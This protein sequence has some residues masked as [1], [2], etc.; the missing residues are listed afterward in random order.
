MRGEY[1][2]KIVQEST[3]EK[4]FETF[5]S[6]FQDGNMMMTYEDLMQ[7]I[8]PFSYGLKSREEISE[9]L[10]DME[11][12]SKFFTFDFDKSKLFSIEEYITM[13]IMLQTTR[14]D[15][16]ALKKIEL[17]PE[18]FLNF[19]DDMQK[20][21]GYNFIMINS[22]ITSRILVINEETVMKNKQNLL[23]YFFGGKTVMEISKYEK[24]QAKLRKEVLEFQFRSHEEEKGRISVDSFFK[25]LASAYHPNRTRH[26]LDK[27]KDQS[28]GH[29]IDF[30]EF[31]SVKMFLYQWEG[32]F[33]SSGTHETLS[34][35]QLK[36]RYLRFCIDKRYRH[37]DRAIEA[38]FNF[39]DIN[40]DRHLSYNEINNYLK[41]LRS[42]GRSSNSKAGNVLLKPVGITGS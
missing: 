31:F 27:I 38:F 21:Y 33:G 24:L 6:A 18:D 19:I 13:L 5:A 22:K 10:R 42:N 9:I 35:Q 14:S 4:I 25:I 34:L 26:I 17:T 29:Y 12:T 20:K 11:K 8:T 41:I 30:D 3:I 16:K 37:S 23:H 7:S 40:H 36:R 28:E 39:L 1:L 2:N 32:D 15:I